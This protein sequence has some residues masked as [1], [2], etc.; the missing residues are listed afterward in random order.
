[1]SR[2]VTY[3]LRMIGEPTTG[4]WCDTCLLPSA[5][6]ATFGIYTP[7]GRLVGRHEFVHC[8]DHEEAGRG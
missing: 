4:E 2:S 1:M 7:S 6:R 3:E 8:F 5:I